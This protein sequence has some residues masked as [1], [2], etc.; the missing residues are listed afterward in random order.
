MI[1][2]QLVL[3]KTS[4]HWDMIIKPEGSSFFSNIKII[5]KYFDLIKLFISR[6]FKV[7]YKQTLLGPIWYLIQPILNSGIFTLIFSGFAS[8]PTD[9]IPPYIFYMSGTIVW[10]YFATNMNNASGIFSSN[11]DL[12]S[13]VY[14]PRLTVPIAN[15]VIQIF[16]FLLQF[17][18]L[19]IVIFIFYLNGFDFKIGLD[20]LY[21]P[22]LIFQLSLISIGFGCFFA[23]ITY[24][25]K[26]LALLLG[27]ATQLWM[28]LTPVIYPLSLVNQK[29]VIFYSLNPVSSIIENFRLILF[30]SGN[31]N[32]NLTILSSLMTILIFTFG[33][34]IFSKVERKFMDTI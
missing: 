12:F 26:D 11:K 33:L 27:F 23:S 14:F 5:Y 19:S 34:S 24:K 18:L 29:Y 30:D 31:F 15:S 10:T 22:M 28:F 6:D 7:Y 9:G 13:K 32:L 16:Q 4:S 3:S 1:K 25:Y 17:I 20:L 8:M 2:H 21:I